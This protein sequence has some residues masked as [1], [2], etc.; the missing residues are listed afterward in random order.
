MFLANLSLG[1]FL[2]LLG[3]ASGLTVALYLLSRTRRKHVVSTLK[4]W[5]SSLDPVQSHRRRRIDQPWSLILQLLS[6]ALLLLAI[7]QP[8]WGSRDSG[9]R[10]YV[11][12]LDTSSWMGARGV[13]LQTKQAALRW[14]RSLG[15]QDRVM[16]VRAGALPE[17]V[18]RFESERGP[19][20]TAIRDSHP[21]AGAL[22]LGR[23]VDFARQAQHVQG[24]RSGEIVYCGGGRIEGI[25]PASSQNLRWLPV[26][27]PREN[28]GLTKVALRRTGQD[29]GLW[30]V[31]LTI[32][33]YGPAP[34][35]AAVALVFGGAPAGSR[36]VTVPARADAITEIGL[37]TNAAGIVEARLLAGDALPAD[38]QVAIEIP[39]QKPL[40]IAVYS[41]EPALLRPVLAAEP[42]LE[43]K[44]LPTAAYQP[45]PD[46]DL[47]L[48][49]G[50]KAP[51][52]PQLPALWIPASPAASPVPVRTTSAAAIIVSWQNDHPLAAGLRTRDAKVGSALIFNPAAGDTV[53]ASSAEGPL[54]VARRAGVKLAIFGFH[55]FRS[56]L[57]YELAAPLLMANFLQWVAPES[58]LRT[59]VLAGAVGPLSV[60]IAPAE[61]AAVRVVAD[62]GG[63]VPFTIDGNQ[64]RLFVPQPGTLRVLTPGSERVFS[65][66]LP[67]V[68]SVNWDAPPQV[69]RGQPPRAAST[70]IP[71]ELWPWFALL[72]A[73]GLLAEWVLF[74]K[75]GNV[76]RILR[77]AA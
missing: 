38:D 28:L 76:P 7:A 41:D 5:R 23:A 67:Q 59:D 20:E 62:G 54:L 64:L 58:F 45:K 42:R 26:D 33:N 68:A 43:A 48:L 27:L 4:F 55:P 6:I 66:S 22:D 49:D 29:G 63:A 69:T 44:F 70:A 21:G 11:L 51:A 8:R 50:V 32:H 24:G 17:S 10:D 9:A 2:A 61:A 31:F 57:Q 15:A 16:V 75:G 74:G 53:V 34:R 37:R 14:V 40:R 77:R 19:V 36:S 35:T 39:A 72:G 65:L 1:E 73:L 12:L 3:A 25:P 60:E 71:R 52:P 30:A 13:E 46:A 47:L 56:P 18:T